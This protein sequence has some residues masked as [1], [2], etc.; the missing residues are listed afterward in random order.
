MN[1]NS[2]PVEILTLIVTLYPELFLVFLSIN[3]KCNRVVKAILPTS[4]DVFVDYSKFP[5]MIFNDVCSHGI[6]PLVRMGFRFKD[7]IDISEGLCNSLAK[8][9][10]H[11]ADLCFPHLIKNSGFDIHSIL[12]FVCSKNAPNSIS[13]AEWCF[14]KGANKVESV[15]FR[16]AFT[17]SLFAGNVPLINWFF[18]KG[19]TVSGSFYYQSN[20]YI[21]ENLLKLMKEKKGTL[22]RKCVTE[23]N[24]RKE[25]YDDYFK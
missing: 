13:A 5:K 21:F 10:F 19:F 9:H 3:K 25:E 7:D 23:I 18:E 2:L 22:S 6:L 11:V 1:L 17:K 16:F 20:V 12:A 15:G 24:K 4:S 8:G 14:N